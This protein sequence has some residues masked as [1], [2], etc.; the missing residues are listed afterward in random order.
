MS[1]LTLTGS[2]NLAGG[3]DA[4]K[5]AAFTLLNQTMQTLMVGVVCRWLCCAC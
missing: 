4:V 1:T 3:Q 5:M 2:V